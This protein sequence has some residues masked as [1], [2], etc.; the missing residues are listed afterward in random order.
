MKYGREK[1]HNPV[2]E[3]D[4]HISEAAGNSFPC[5]RNSPPGSIWT[6][7]C[8][9]YDVLDLAIQ[10]SDE[11]VIMGHK[12]IDL[13]ALGSALGLLNYTLENG[14]KA[15]VYINPSELN[16][17]VVKAMDMLPKKYKKYIITDDSKIKAGRHSLLVVMDTFKTKVVED[18]D[19]FNKFSNPIIIPIVA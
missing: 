14:K 8:N 15:Y 9:I 18:L 16:Y 2:N 1:R 6:E 13:D 11:I 17:S 7:N 12:Y 3:A 10:M 5:P 19:L 4:R